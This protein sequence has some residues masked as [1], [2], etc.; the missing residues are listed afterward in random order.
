MSGF[1][2]TFSR[3]EIEFKKIGN[4]SKFE[5]TFNGELQYILGEG[6]VFINRLTT[7][8]L[9]IPEWDN[10]PEPFDANALKPT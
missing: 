9:N 5:V 6:T 3:G 2:Y 10:S 8:K 7:K 1:K 4:T